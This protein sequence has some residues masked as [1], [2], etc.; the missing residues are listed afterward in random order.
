MYMPYLITLNTSICFYFCFLSTFAYHSDEGYIMHDR[1][2]TSGYT[3]YAGT[4]TAKMSST[5]RHSRK[6]SVAQ[7]RSTTSR[8]CRMDYQPGH[9][10]RIGPFKRGFRDRSFSLNLGYTNPQSFDI[11]Y[12]TLSLIHI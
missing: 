5:F 4:R 1:V 11:H 9:K 8:G 2:W 6:N 10:A 12:I 3:T 7:L